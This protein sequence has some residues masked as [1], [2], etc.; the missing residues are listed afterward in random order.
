MEGYSTVVTD[1]IDSPHPQVLSYLQLGLYIERCNI[2]EGRYLYSFIIHN[3]VIELEFRLML[4]VQQ[5]Q[6]YLY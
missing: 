2:E 5:N 1:K 4:L 3:P 6:L